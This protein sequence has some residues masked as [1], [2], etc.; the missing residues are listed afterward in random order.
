MGYY[1][2][3][4]SLVSTFYVNT[5]T[6]AAPSFSTNIYA[7]STYTS[8]L[9]QTR[10]AAIL[11]DQGKVVV[12]SGRVFRKVQ[13]MCSTGAVQNGG[14]DGVGGQD[15]APSNYITGYIELPGSNNG[16]SG[17]PWSFAA[18]VGTMAPVARLG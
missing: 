4:G 5:G 7:Q 3:L 15:S 16:G 14:T 11:R 17:A 10:G 8:S 18:A 12:S 13:L 9:L 1:I 6:D 2:N